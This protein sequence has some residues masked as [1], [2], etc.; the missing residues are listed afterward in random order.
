M[1]ALDLPR[2]HVPPVRTGPRLDPDAPGRI[3]TAIGVA[4]FLALFGSL[5]Q[6]PY[7]WQAQILLVPATVGLFVIVGVRTKPLREIKI[8]PW[9]FPILVWVLMSIGWTTGNLSAS[10][11]EAAL[12]LAL[13]LSVHVAGSVFDARGVLSFL[14]GASVLLAIVVLIDAA[15]RPGRAFSAGQGELE[16]LGLRSFFYQKN[17]LGGALVLGFSVRAA[18][19]RHW[20]RITYTALVIVLLVLARSSTAMIAAASIA[21]LQAL[22]ARIIVERRRGQ[23]GSTF[24]LAGL[25]LILGAIAVAVFNPLVAATTKRYETLSSQNGAAASAE[26]SFG[27]DGLWFRQGDEQGQWV[28]HADRASPDGTTIYGVTFISFGETGGPRTRIA[29]EQA[30]VSPLLEGTELSG[31]RCVLINITASR[32]LKMSE[33]RDAVK[34]VQ[35]FAASEAFVKYGTVFDENMEDRIRVTVVATGLGAVRAAAMPRKME[36][37][38][39]GTDNVSME[40]DYGNLELPAVIRRTSRTTVEAMS[41][42]GMSTLDIPAFLRKQ[43]D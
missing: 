9:L 32:N 24:I 29:A 33:V 14:A 4:P 21:V 30:A 39:T 38:R 23:S 27:E 17:S 36:V 31:A 20:L 34:T 35:A 16:S 15:V 18:I 42:N 11:Q 1:T 5:M 10:V 8:D 13:V 7:M 40:I 22:S 19:R 28:I 2:R 12:A 26:A 3:P 37:I 6:V 41:A 43:A 25:A